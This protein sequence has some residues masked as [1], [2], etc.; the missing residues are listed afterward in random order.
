MQLVLSVGG[1]VLD[2]VELKK[3]F[4]KDEDYIYALRRLL[5]FKHK[6]AILALLTPPEIYIEV[7][8]K[9]K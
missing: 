8:S 1:K 4:F 6:L 5:L 3:E 2:T 7:P 9:A